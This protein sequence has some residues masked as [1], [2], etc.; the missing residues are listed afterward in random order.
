ML[1]AHAEGTP[2]IHTQ[3]AEQAIAVLRGEAARVDT[4]PPSR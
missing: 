1:A 4:S 2:L 3:T